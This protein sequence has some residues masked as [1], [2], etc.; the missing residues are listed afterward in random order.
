MPRRPPASGLTR[1]RLL[2][3]IPSHEYGGAERYAVRIARAAAS[4]WDVLAAI[5]RGESVGQLRR[6]LVDQ[7]TGVVHLAAAQRA[8]GVVG[9]ANL[10]RHYRPDVVHLTLP[11]PRFAQEIRVGRALTGVP[12]VV[13]HQ[14]VG[15]LSELAGSATWLYRWLHRRGERWVAVS[16][17]GRRMLAEAFGVPPGT[18]D[19]IYNGA[20]QSRVGRDAGEARE[21]MRA[22]LGLNSADELVLSVGRLSLEKGHDLLIEVARTLIPGRPG[23]Q[24]WIAGEGKAR[25]DLER[26]VEESGLTGRVRLLGHVSYVDDLMVAA[27]A[28][29]FPSRREGTPFA[30]IEAMSAGLPVVA[31]RFGGADEVVA[32]ELNGLLV[33]KDDRAGLTDALVRLLDDRELADRLSMQAPLVEERFSDETMVAETLSLLASVASRQSI[34]LRQGDQPSVAVEREK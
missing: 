27:D 21:R 34:D 1:G 31:T 28:F 30:L 25:A 18:V 14:Q 13:C 3:V 24:V 6:D 5:R 16:D 12:A 17:Y 32:P 4:E 10:L 9:F 22:D 2:V 23:L 19:V 29:A 7:G 15:D 11:W 8:R 26:R 33:A 20:F